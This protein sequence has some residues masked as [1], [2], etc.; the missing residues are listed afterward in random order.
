[1]ERAIRAM[2]TNARYTYADYENWDDDKRCELIDGAIHMMTPMPSSAHQDISGELFSRLHTF[3]RGKP[4]K[5]FH[6]PYDVRLNAD[7]GDD[8]VVQPDLFVVC[9]RSKISQKGCKG[10]PDMVI[11]I[12]SPSTASR[13]AILKLNKYLQAGVNE[14]WIVD[15][16][17]KN[18]SVHVLKDGK[19]V[20]SVYSETD[21]IPVNTLD[22]CRIN[23]KEVFENIW[24][25][26]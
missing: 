22:G 21:V 9:D 2:Q 15:P 1:M 13:D 23:M 25:D 20:V 6:P 19:Y 10:A 5:V 26:E 12:L 18:T 4:C 24:E 8:T 3:L 11:E 7:S 14:Y 16:E 17:S